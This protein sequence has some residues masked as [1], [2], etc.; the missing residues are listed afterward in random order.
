MQHPPEQVGSRHRCAEF[1]TGKDKCTSQVLY[2][3]PHRHVKNSSLPSTQRRRPDRCLTIRWHPRL[4]MLLSPR[5]TAIP[6]GNWTPRASLL[7]A[8]Y[9]PGL[10]PETLPPQAL[11]AHNVL[12]DRRDVTNSRPKVPAC[13]SDAEKSTVESW[14][15]Q[16]K[17]L[18]ETRISDYRCPRP[19]AAV[20]SSEPS[21]CS[22]Q[23]TY[24][25][26]NRMLQIAELLDLILYFAGPVA[27]LQSLRVS[28]SWRASALSAI[29]NS[30]NADAFRFPHPCTPVE[31]GQLIEDGIA[32]PL[33]PSPDEIKQFSLH[34]EQTMKQRSDSKYSKKLYLP[35]IFT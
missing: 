17:E 14:R 20:A 31:Y 12:N 26:E 24:R 5:K 27:Q 35:A 19:E 11:Q 33:Q 16:V 28:R 7:C 32:A 8:M 2:R 25:S 29:R 4:P 10:D 6:N 30:S 22:H 18:V 1:G 23:H 21:L 9:E 34:V 3:R 13:Y 15:Q